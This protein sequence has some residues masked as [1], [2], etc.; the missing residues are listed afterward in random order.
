MHNAAQSGHVECVREL[1]IRGADVNMK[2]RG[3]ITP[4]LAAA[5]GGNLETLQ[6]LLES[7]A[8]VNFKNDLQTSLSGI[9]NKPVYSSL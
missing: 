3:A 9:R 7:G 4:L 6:L 2:D 8:N 5:K 1:V